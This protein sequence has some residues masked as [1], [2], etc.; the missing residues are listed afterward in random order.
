MF[1]EDGQ[2]SGIIAGVSENFELKTSATTRDASHEASHYGN[3]Y[4]IA[5]NFVALLTASGEVGCIYLKYTGSSTLHIH[6]I[7]LSSNVETKWRLYTGV[8]STTMSVAVTPVNSNSKFNRSLLA[9]VYKPADSS[10]L[11]VAGGSIVDQL[12]QQA[13]VQTISPNG[14]LLLGQNNVIALTAQLS[15]NGTI[16]ATFEVYEET[17]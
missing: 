10:T 14:S 1:I 6:N 17:E 13:G 3:D 8:T 4:R 9:T 2:G 11:V 12:I 16:S 7:R 5:T 15:A